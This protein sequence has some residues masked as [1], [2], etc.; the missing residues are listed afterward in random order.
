M[1]CLPLSALFI[2]QAGLSYWLSIR[3]L[4]RVEDCFFNVPYREALIIRFKTM[5]VH[6]EN[7]IYVWA[8]NFNSIMRKYVGD[9]E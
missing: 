6:L 3:C 8:L 1:G 9:D 2:V 7:F 4:R 5:S